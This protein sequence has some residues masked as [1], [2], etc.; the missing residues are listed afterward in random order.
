MVDFNL[1]SGEPVI[2]DDIDIVLQQID[3]LFDSTPEEV[4]GYEDFGTTYDEY[5]YQLK[6]SA[7][8]LKETVLNDLASINLM[9]F[10][11]EVEVLLLQGT[12]QDIALINI[13]LTRYNEQYTKTYKIE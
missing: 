7:D 10:V 5:L 8:A 12:E 3:I 13:D 6:I 9:G 2:Y 4:L 11:P 1:N